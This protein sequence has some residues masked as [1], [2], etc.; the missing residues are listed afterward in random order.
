M[1]Q[2]AGLGF[3][4]PPGA[5]QDSGDSIDV[6]HRMQPIATRFQPLAGPEIRGAAMVDEHHHILNL[7]SRTFQLGNPIQH[8]ATCN[9]DIVHDHHQITLL[10]IALN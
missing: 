10:K 7:E 1:L 6:Q 2:K 4:K 5:V 8:A 9:Q 3:I